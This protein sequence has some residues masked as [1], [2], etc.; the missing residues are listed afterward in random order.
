MITSDKGIDLIKNFEGFHTKRY[1]C[2]AGKPTIGYGHLLPKGSTLQEIDESTA[3]QLLFSDLRGVERAIARLV[4]VPMLQCQYDALVSFVF[5][6]GAGRLQSSTLRMKLNRGEYESAADEF[7]KWVYA[8]GKRMKGLIRRR[9]AERA[10]FL[11]ES[12][13]I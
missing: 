12:H 8:G 2:P 4:V 7:P 10:M 5:N 13:D 3:E 6:L 11:G 1:I 9:E